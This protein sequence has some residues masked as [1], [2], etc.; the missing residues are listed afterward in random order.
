MAQ[1][2]NEQVSNMF[3]AAKQALNDDLKQNFYNAAINR[4]TAFRQLNNNANAK[5]ALYSGLP[6]ATQMAYDR[7]TFLPGTASMAQKALAKQKENQDAWDEYMEYMDKL[8]EQANYY[9]G[10]ANEIKSKYAQYGS[11]AGSQDK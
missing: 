6:A 1:D 3:N 4:Q 8:N 10:L 9:N 2:I 7:D 5:H 11:Y